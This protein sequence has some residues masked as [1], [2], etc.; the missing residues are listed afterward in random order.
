METNAVVL[1]I[2]TQNT[3]QEVGA[4][5]PSKLDV[6]LV[7]I[8]RYET[9]AYEVYMEDQLQDMFKM[10]ENSGP[11]IGY[12]SISFDMG[13]LN[14]YY[15]GD[16]LKLPQIDLMVQIQEVA[17]FRP[18]LDH[19]AHSTL[20][21]GKSG[22]GLDAVRYWKNGQIDELKK[23]CLDDVKV[24]KELYEFGVNN[25]FVKVA[26]KMGQEMEVKVSF[27]SEKQDT[28]VPLTLGL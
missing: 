10:L 26:N 27:E 15:S 5:E 25:G 23:Y 24:T 1:D 22:D 28:S 3:F 2:E 17:G 16:L 20:G 9:D 14:K 8:Y 21:I 13:C 12:N 6:S 18:K 19:V 7:G 4:Y 11:I